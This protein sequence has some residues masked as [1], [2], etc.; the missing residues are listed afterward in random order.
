MSSVAPTSRLLLAPLYAGSIWLEGRAARAGVPIPLR[1]PR[2]VFEIRS[3]P[4]RLFTLLQ[5]AGACPRDAE[6]VDVRR[7]GALENEPDKER[8]AAALDVVMRRGEVTSTLPVFVKF[9]SGRGLP[10]LLQAVRAAVE[11]KVAREVDFYRR[12][13]DSVPLRTPRVYFADAR[14]AFNRVC[15]VLEH[16]E[17]FNLAD[18]RGCPVSAMRAML[19]SVARMNA[20][21]AGRTA[22]DARTRWIPARAGLDYADFVATLGGV[23]AR[24]KGL[25]RALDRYFRGRPVTLVHGDC[26]PGN[27]LF[28][29]DGTLAR[30]IHDPARPEPDPWPASSEPLPEVVFADWEAVNVAPLLWDFTYGTVIGLRPIDREAHSRRL[31]DEFLSTLRAGGVATEDCDRDRALVEIDLL[32]LVLY[33][34]ASLIVSKGY[35]DNQGNTLDDYR[36][37]SHRIVAAV[38]AVDV[39]RASRALFVSPDAARRL[40]REAF[41]EPR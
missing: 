28:L 5:A 6:L 10:L 19:V 9:Q 7:R 40:Q 33:F 32:T 20:A 3:A 2:D 26:R 23:P 29:D 17:G 41:F 4:E 11:P 14:H 12:L 36:A 1:F 37:W 15:I 24:Y 18:W 25:W 35:W 22:L 27:V 16:V 21:F 34:L 39:D 13:A 8:T 31:L 30:R 38:R